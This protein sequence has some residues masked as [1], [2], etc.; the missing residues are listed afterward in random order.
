MTLDGRVTVPGARWVSGEEARAGS[1]TSCEP[2]PTPS[3]SGWGRC[4]RT[5]PGS[6]RAT[7]RSSASR[8][9]SRSAGPAAGDVRA[10][11]AHRAARRRSW[12]RSPREG[13][14][15]L[16]LEGGPT[17]AAAFL[18]ADLVDKVLLFVA[19]TALGRRAAL[20]RRLSP[21]RAACSDLSTRAPSAPTS[22]SRPTSTSPEACASLPACSRGSCGR[23]G[24]SRPSTATTAGIRLVLD[25][26]ATAPAV[27]GRR[28]G[29]DQRRLPHGRVGRGTAASAFHAVPETLARTTLG[30]PRGRA[31]EVNVEPALRAGEPL[32]GHYVQGH[33]DGDRRAS[34]RSRR[35]ARASASSSRRRPRSF[36]TASRRARSRSRASR[37]RSRSSTTTRSRSRSSRTRS[38]RRRWPSSHPGREVNLEADVLAK[39]VERLLEPRAAAG[40]R[41]P[42]VAGYDAAD[43]HG[44]A[45]HRLRNRS[46]R[47]SRTIRAGRF[48]VV[49]DD[50]DRENEGDLTIAAQFATPEAVNFMATHG[51]GL[52]CLCLTP[53]RCERARAAADDRSER[54]A[55]RHR[56]HR[57]DR[58][59]RGRHHRDLGARPR[60]HDPGRDRPA[61]DRRTTSSSP[62][63]SSRSRPARAA[64]SSARARPR[65]PSTSRGSP[66]SHRPASS[67]RS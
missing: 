12:P 18:A 15:S 47:R 43:E 42:G 62:A 54:D 55:V 41:S 57:L 65:P 16:L 67:A 22:C 17:L 1:C 11:A 21:R 45:E 37:S 61:L 6:T 5:R 25:A 59:A 53:E 7:S 56:L 51:R 32:G 20:A 9:G 14:Q 23:S 64:C 31:T 3:R 10:R 60:A 34:S 28:L 52:I 2:P 8:G 38:R 27:R 33:V 26:P 39:Y 58:G 19:P 46:R 50:E 40:A 4:G 35:R 49:V 24:V 44:S 30:G 29:G 63:T 36:A 66:A 13:V 48:V